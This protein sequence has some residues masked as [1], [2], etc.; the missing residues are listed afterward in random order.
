MLAVKTS[1]LSLENIQLMGRVV[2]AKYLVGKPF[3]DIMAETVPNLAKTM[4]SDA[5]SSVSLT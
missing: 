5:R 2:R 4:N 1:S 3:E